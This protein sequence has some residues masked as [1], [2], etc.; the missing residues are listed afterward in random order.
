MK[1]NWKVRLANKTFWITA[2]PTT[3]LLISQ[4]LAMFGIT[5]DGTT[6]SSQLT[7]IVG[8][9]FGMLALLGVANDPTTAGLD[10]STQAMTYIAPKQ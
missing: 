4:A 10:D 3:L 1:I 9:V 8:T 5:F 2:I 6:L 7:G